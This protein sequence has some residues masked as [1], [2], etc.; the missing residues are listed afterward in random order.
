MARICLYNNKINLLYKLKIRL[1]MFYLRAPGTG[2][3]PGIAMCSGTTI[4]RTFYSFKSKC[5]GTFTGPGS[6]RGPES[7][8]G[9][10]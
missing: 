6:F 2:Q 1:I 3:S 10:G 9:R 8:L 5:P 7:E 4:P